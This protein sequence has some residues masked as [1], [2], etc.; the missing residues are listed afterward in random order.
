MVDDKSVWQEIREGNKDSLSK[1]FVEYYDDLF[2]YAKRFERYD[3]TI[4]DLIQELFL[5]LWN[6]HSR[7]GDAPNI[8]AYLFRSL[9]NMSINKRKSV[10]MVTEELKEDA[11]NYTPEDFNS[12]DD[13]LEM[14]KQKLLPV[15]NELP[16]QQREAIYLKYF[17]GLNIDEIAEVME[18][19]N[20]SVRNNLHRAMLKLREKMVL[21]L[22]YFC[23]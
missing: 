5:T 6:K 12:P 1:I 23:F 13:L 20:Q 11:F 2:C 7:L 16:P 9:R 14:R 15:L 19:T 21:Q 10:R 17:Q 22:F 8:R 18:Q 4:K 3:D